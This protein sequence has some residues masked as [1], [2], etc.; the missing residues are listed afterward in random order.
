[1]SRLRLRT[2]TTL[3]EGAESHAAFFSLSI[4]HAQHFGPALG[5]CCQRKKKRKKKDV[6]IARLPLERS[7]LWLL[8]ILTGCPARFVQLLLRKLPT[9]FLLLWGPTADVAV[10][11]KYRDLRRSWKLVELILVMVP[12]LEEGGKR[13][14]Q[15]II[16]TFG[17]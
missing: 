5:M 16:K 13:Y 12:D 7:L 4:E 3:S 14:P 9:H 6:C 15:S 1:M 8:G 2:Q 10:M 11:G 17:G